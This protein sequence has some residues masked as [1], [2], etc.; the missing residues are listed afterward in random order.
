VEVDI[1]QVS[2]ATK[3]AVWSSI[4]HS[5]PV[6]QASGTIFVQVM[7]PLTLTSTVSDSIDIIVHRYALDDFTYGLPRPCSLIPTSTLVTRR[8]KLVLPQL[9]E[10]ESDSEDEFIE[11]SE[12]SRT[13]HVSKPT[14][15]NLTLYKNIPEN[16]KSAIIDTNVKMDNNKAG[17]LDSLYALPDFTDTT[18]FRWS[19][20]KLADELRKRKKRE[21][22]LESGSVFEQV[23]YV[24]TEQSSSD[25]NGRKIVEIAN[26]SCMSSVVHNVSDFITRSTKFSHSIL[27]EST[28]L[29]SLSLGSSVTC[30]STSLTYPGIGTVT[31][32]AANV[33]TTLPIPIYNYLNGTLYALPAG[34][35]L[36][37]IIW[38]ASSTSFAVTGPVVGNIPFGIFVGETLTVNRSYVAVSLDRPLLISTAGAP[39]SFPIIIQPHF[40]GVNNQAPDD[41]SWFASMY[42][43]YRGSV[44]LRI[45]GNNSSYVLLRDPLNALSVNTP[46]F[47]AVDPLLNDFKP[48][49]KSYSTNYSVAQAIDPFV[50]GFGE[51]YVPFDAKTNVLSINL[52]ETLDP[53]TAMANAYLPATKLYLVPYET[54]TT[55]DIWRSA[56]EDFEFFYLNGPSFLLDVSV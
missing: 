1:D 35:V 13:I 18:A 10:K 33:V 7:N 46:S 41:L 29:E 8:S 16:V 49:E 38:E 44:R 24:D 26:D 51:V 3:T 55:L 5:L 30:T 15:A 31:I 4:T 23:D 6:T 37:T 50:E 32:P 21:T 47:G 12:G 53:T 22:V 17:L 34:S 9:P 42:T 27:V 11:Y 48:Y 54:V 40:L 39:V 19:K 25:P 2:N 28:T 14:K 45:V 56:G 52:T 20:A 36:S 43:Y